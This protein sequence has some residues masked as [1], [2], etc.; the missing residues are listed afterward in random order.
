MNQQPPV[1]KG[2]ILHGINN[3]RAEIKAVCG[4]AATSHESGRVLFFLSLLSLLSPLPPQAPAPP[5]GSP[6][7][8]THQRPG[9]SGRSPG[10]RADW[11]LFSAGPTASIRPY[12]MQFRWPLF[13]CKGQ[14]LLPDDRGVV[15]TPRRGT[16]KKKKERKKESHMRPSPS[17]TRYY[18]AMRAWPPL[19]WVITGWSGQHPNPPLSSS[20]GCRVC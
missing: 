13:S 4:T 5:H 6:E 2:W 14:W 10:A 11:R 17:V 18:R 7:S 19:P 1:I 15:Q 16:N 9:A 12:Q 8:T 3:E 20:P